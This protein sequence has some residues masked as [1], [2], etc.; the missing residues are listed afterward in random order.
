MDTKSTHKATKF[1]KKTLAEKLDKLAENVSRRGIFVVIKENNYYHI[2]EAF[3]KRV[4]LHTIYSKLVADN[5]CAKLNQTR[6]SK[7]KLSFNKAQT[8]V[9][10]HADYMIEAE[11]YKHTIKSASDSF[12]REI[13]FVRLDEV[14]LKAR[15]VLKEIPF[16]F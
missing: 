8:I 12:Q 6:K 5:L 13:A 9:L 15:T 2:V 16:S 14:T 7:Q 10:K 1:D 11:T 3:D 4:V